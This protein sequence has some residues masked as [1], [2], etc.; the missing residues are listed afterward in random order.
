MDQGHQLLFLV[1]QASNFIHPKKPTQLLTVWKLSSYKKNSL[2]RDSCFLCGL[3]H[4]TIERLHFLF[5]VRDERI[6]ENT[7]M[8]I[9]FNWVP[10]FQ[11]D[12]SVARRRIRRLNVWCYMRC[13]TV[14]FGVCNLVRLLHLPCYKS[15]K[16]SADRLRRLV[17]SNCKVC[18]SA[19][20]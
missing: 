8:G 18:K 7:E 20:V 14:V 10:K 4:A 15:M 5:V 6:W 16:T 1:H 12:N 9:Y 11:G 3:R 17:W 19:I 13:S 2:T